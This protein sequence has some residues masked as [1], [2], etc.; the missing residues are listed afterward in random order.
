MTP[1]VFNLIIIV[2][3]FIILV[4]ASDL[5]V[6]GITN[7]AKKLGMSDYLIGLVIV[8]ITASIPELVASFTGAV[9]N[10]SGIVFGTIL[11]SN[12]AGFTIILGILANIIF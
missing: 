12:I 5:T 9:I 2:A 7:Y 1:L 3:S 10:S 11:G 6:F 8:S 4:K